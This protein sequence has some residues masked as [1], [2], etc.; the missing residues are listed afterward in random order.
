MHHF[1][2][3]VFVFLWGL[4]R[5]LDFWSCVPSM[6]AGMPAQLLS[7]VQLLATPW[8]RAHQAPLSTGFSRREYWSGLPFPPPGDLHNQRSDPH[9]LHCLADSF[10][11][12]PPGKPPSLSVVSMFFSLSPFHC[13]LDS[14][15]ESV[16]FV[17]CV[18]MSFLWSSISVWRSFWLFKKW[19]CL[20]G[21][22][23]EF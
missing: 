9:P 10:T 7:H 19:V 5:P 13:V 11:A 1:S 3:W 17:Y 20:F 16:C 4:L 2:N 6:S 14:G 23:T 15:F 12:A 21:F 18:V 22:F 8:N